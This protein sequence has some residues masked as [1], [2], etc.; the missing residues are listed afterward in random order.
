MNLSLRVG[1][2]LLCG[3]VVAWSWW[4]MLQ[5]PSGATD[6]QWRTLA[7][8]MNIASDDEIV[9]LPAWQLRALVFFPAE[10]V[11]SADGF[12]TWPE[13][14]FHTSPRLWIVD[15][16]DAL[17]QQPTSAA[18][19]RVRALPVLSS[20]G[21]LRA[22]LWE[23]T[24]VARRLPLAQVLSDEG[25][26]SVERN[27]VRCGSVQHMEHHWVLATDNGVRAWDILVPAAPHWLELQGQVPITATSI[28]VFAGHPRHAIQKGA[29]IDIRIHDDDQALATLRR[30]PTFFIDPQRRHRRSWF[31]PGARR[32]DDRGYRADVIALPIREHGPTDPPMRTIRMRLQSAGAA[33]PF[34]LD[35]IMDE[36][37]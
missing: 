30:E 26:C 4:L 11:R 33:T 35:V 10:Q 2:W 19:G 22:R 14:A 29:P 1:C 31:I 24:H 3:A 28:S 34:A 37:P 12:A 7:A 21:P 36:S 17:D 9:V 25:P 18:I 6:E 23:R 27:R 5:R 8:N 13:S 20:V 15:E 16:H 32:D